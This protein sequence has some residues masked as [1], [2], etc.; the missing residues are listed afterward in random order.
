MKFK[1]G[2][3]VRRTDDLYGDNLILTV[4][5]YNDERKGEG[6]PAMFY[7]LEGASRVGH[8]L[9]GHRGPWLDEHFE[10][11]PVPSTAPP[12]PPGFTD[13]DGNHVSAG[14]DALYAP[15]KMVMPRR[16]KV[17][18]VLQD[19]DAYV[20]YYHEDGSLSDRHFEVKW[21]W[22]YAVPEGWIHAAE[23]G[24]R[25]AIE[26]REEGSLPVLGPGY[27]PM[28][29]SDYLERFRQILDNMLATTTAKNHDYAGLEDA[30]ANF[31]MVESMGLAPTETGIL[32]RMTDKL[33]RVSN[34]LQREAKVK[35]EA[36]GQTLLD[37]AVYSIILAI[38][39]EHKG[40]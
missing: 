25:Q 37:L 30:F 23:R 17:H 28:S 9:Q 19:G 1:V 15:G 7:S 39:L 22:L 8:S 20:S 38:Y 3:K 27:T 11:V 10:L 21:N 18:D 4:E 6:I 33:I 36:I 32:T 14:E 12:R 13:K 31:R 40:A 16:V 24:P 2:D 5:R 34:L 29:P 35:D 26:L